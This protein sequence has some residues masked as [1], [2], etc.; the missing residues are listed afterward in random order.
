MLTEIFSK[1]MKKRHY[2]GK[3]LKEGRTFLGE[4]IIKVEPD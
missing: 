2:Y 1:D 3:E 4:T